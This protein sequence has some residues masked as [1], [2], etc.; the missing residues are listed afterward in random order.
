M[1]FVA[2]QKNPK[3]PLNQKLYSMVS[4]GSHGSGLEHPAQGPQP[5]PKARIKRTVET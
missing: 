2:I 1:E 4:Q 5:P 3:T